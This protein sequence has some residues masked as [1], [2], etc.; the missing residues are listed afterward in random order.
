[1]RLN[2][3]E[4]GGERQ[5]SI[6]GGAE[7]DQVPY[8]MLKGGIET[9]FATNLRSEVRMNHG[10]PDSFAARAVATHTGVGS[11]KH[12]EKRMLLTARRNTAAR[13]DHREK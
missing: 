9:L 6:R 3:P 7:H 10:S 13:A 1:M 4:C 5:C 11:V 8:A 2:S 12:F